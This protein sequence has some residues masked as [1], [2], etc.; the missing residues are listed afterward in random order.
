MSYQINHVKMLHGVSGETVRNWIDVF[1]SYFSEGASPG[2][3][4]Q[5]NFTVE[6]MKVFDFIASERKRGM[7]MEEIGV[8]LANGTRGS[9]PPMPDDIRLRLADNNLQTSVV[10]NKFEELRGEF[11]VIGSQIDA[12]I[13]TAEERE[14]LVSLQAMLEEKD[15]HIAFLERKV[16][17]YEADDKRMEEKAARIERATDDIF[18]QIGAIQER[19]KGYADR[20]NGGEGN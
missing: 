18:K 16:E 20:Q 7:K 14:M 4:R 6:D 13:M 5:R 9:E 8:S 3:G 1:I 12:L 11:S 10:L 17:Q 15:K 2:K 19:V